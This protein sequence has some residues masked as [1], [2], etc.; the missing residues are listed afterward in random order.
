MRKARR[1]ASMTWYSTTDSDVAS[2]R[3]KLILYAGMTMLVMLLIFL[4]S[5][6]DGTESGELSEWLLETPVGQW[7]M[8]VL[9]ELT[10]E[11][12]HLDIRKYGHM[13]EYA[14]LAVC[15]C[16]FFRTL[17]RERIPKIGARSCL[18]FC[19]LYACTDEFHQL[20]VPGRGGRLTDVLIDCAGAL[21]GILLIW[22]ASLLERRQHEQ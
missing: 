8:E 20:F 22:L 14:L 7:V 19:A 10:G 3:S 2:R 5:A 9:P 16:L 11:G 12:D 1:S 6:Q 13:T 18:S 15:S 4:F 17:F 21:M